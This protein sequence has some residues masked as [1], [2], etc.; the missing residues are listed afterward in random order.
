MAYLPITQH[1]LIGDLHTAALVAADGRVVWLPWPRFDSP[2]LFAALLDDQ[3]GG[4]WALA[5]AGA[6]SS[7]QSYDGETAIL[8]TE[9]EA[10]GGRAELRDWMS[11]WQGAAPGHDLCRVLRCTD[12]QIELRG[13]FAPRP[14]YAR[15]RAQLRARDGGLTFHAHDLDLF[16]S[17]DVPWTLEP[18]GD[19]ATL[20][21]TLRAGEHIHCVLS[22]GQ[23]IGVADVGADLAA[24]RRFWQDWVGRCTYDGRWQALV[25]RSAITLKLLTYAPSGAIV[26]A[27]TTS[28]PEWIGGPRNWDYRYT[29]LRDASLTL[30]AL[31]R[32]GYEQ[33]AHAFFHWLAELRRR[34]GQA[35]QIMYGVGGETELEEHEL[36][37]LAGYRGSRPVRIGN[38]AYRQRQ[39]DV[40]GGI[41]DAAYAYEQHGQLLEPH[42]WD[43][44]RDEIDYVAAHWQT[45]DQGIW[46]IRGPAEHHTFSKLMCWIT[47]DRGIRLAEHERW[48]YDQARWCATRDAIRDAILHNAWNEQLGAFTQ[49]FGGATL[50][51]S[52][53]ILPLVGLLPPDDPRVRSTIAQIDQ[54][55][56]R[57][58][59]VYRYRTGD[60]LPGDEGAF[61]ICS[62]WMVDALATTGQVEAAERRFERLLSYANPLGLLPEEVD[63]ASGTALGNYPQAFSQIGLINSALNLTR[64]LD[65]V[66]QPPAPGTSPHPMQSR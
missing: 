4:E 52:L 47:L 45:P 56:S 14:D 61:L 44:L 10:P 50:D 25:R 37:H 21:T 63:P 29:W 33:E 53:L 30:Y 15:A 8:L 38:A 41:V 48:P 60:H 13:R 12:G 65:Q 51:A 36:S 7:R 64:A 46:E 18:G 49:T 58:A 23:P 16:L 57:G 1:G 5:P 62:F 9:F 27:P 6:T 34:H 32:L 55:L 43:L 20:R 2:S 40:Y 28:L 66:K 11:P 59:L 26:A 24:T 42:E 31:F 54:Q 3:A 22:S 19:A 17:C 35:P 39:L